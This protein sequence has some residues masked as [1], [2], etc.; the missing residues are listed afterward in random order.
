MLSKY[1]IVSIILAATTL[2]APVELETRQS[3]SALQLVHVAGTTEIGLGIVG[4]PLAASLSSSGVTTKS[5]TYDTSAEYIVTVAAG[6]AITTTYLAAQAISCPNQR[7]VLSGYSKGA[8]VLHGLSLSSNLRS[9]IA[10]ILVFGDPARNINSPWPIN[11]P[12]VDLSPK[13]GSS[14]SQNIASFCNTGDLFCAIPGVSLPAHLAYPT[15][16]SIAVAAA[17]AKARP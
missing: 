5:I 9:K 13:D 4:A 16:G 17:F 15:D 1:L 12:S 6:A 7:F 14:S 3:C 8:L 10:S 2:G 11:N